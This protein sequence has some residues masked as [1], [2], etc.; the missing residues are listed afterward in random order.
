MESHTFSIPAGPEGITGL[1]W[2]GNDHLVISGPSET[3]L[4][5]LTGALKSTTKQGARRIFPYPGSRCVRIL[6]YNKEL[7][8]VSCPVD[9][10]WDTQEITQTPGCGVHYCYACAFD[11]DGNFAHG[12]EY[13]E[14]GYWSYIKASGEKITGSTSLPIPFSIAFSPDGSRLLVGGRWSHLAI[15]DL[16]D[17]APNQQQ[18]LKKYTPDSLVS[19]V[20]WS[21]SGQYIA[22]GLLEKYQVEIWD[23][24]TDQMV[25]SLPFGQGLVRNNYW[26]HR[27][28]F[29]PG[30]NHLLMVSNTYGTWIINWREGRLIGS[31]PGWTHFDFSPDGAFLALGSQHGELFIEGLAAYLE[32]IASAEL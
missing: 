27:V 19:A 12:G 20:C 11:A 22:A 7:K 14:W 9:W 28:S 5:S 6:P 8:E 1:L 31:A 13:Y 29:I 17:S 10:H 4:Y 21:P 23:T 26:V 18:P 30:H 2:S 24:Y 32:S 15:W 16:T 25:I 3:G